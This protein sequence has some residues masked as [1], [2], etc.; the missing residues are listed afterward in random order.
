MQYNFKINQT[1]YIPGQITILPKPELRFWE[2]SH[3][4]PPFGVTSAKVAIIAHNCLWKIWEAGLQ[5]NTLPHV[6][7]AMPTKTSLKQQQNTV[8]SCTCFTPLA[9]LL[10]SFGNNTGRKRRH[11]WLNLALTA[12]CCWF[13]QSRTSWRT[14]RCVRYLMVFG[15]QAF[16]R[17]VFLGSGFMSNKRGS[18][19]HFRRSLR[20]GMLHGWSSLAC[21]YRSDSRKTCLI[22]CQGYLPRLLIPIYPALPT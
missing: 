21:S 9:R 13:S 11:K 16:Q 14:K 6:V 1:K 17:W 7:L 4:T 10:T 18:K 5:I 12:R 8:G 15:C 22:P 20:L 19:Y 3:P 2:D